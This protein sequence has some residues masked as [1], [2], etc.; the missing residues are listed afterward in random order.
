[1]FQKIFKSNFIRSSVIFSVASFIVSVIGYLINLIVARSFS[2]SDYGELM[3]AMSYVLFLSVPITT[4]GLIVIQRI[5]KEDTLG[6]K[7]IALDL[8]KW[9]FSELKTHMPLLTI[10][11][12]IFSTLVY[13]KGNLGLPAIIFVVVT[14][15]LM[16]FQIFYSSVLQSFKNF[17]WAGLFLITIILSKFSFAI[18]VI[19]ISPNLINL[20][21]AF[22]LSL[23]IGL[24]VGKKMIGNTKVISD[25]N[26]THKFLNIFSYLKRKGLLI[27][28]ITTLG[29]VG[30]ANVDIILV[31]KF[32]PADQAGLYSSISL[33]GKII[34]YVSMPLSQVAFS[35]FTGKDSKHNSLLILIL[36]SIVYLFIGSVSTFIYFF[37]P[38][39]VINVIF[40]SKFLNISSLIWM[41]AIFGT[42][43]SLVTLYAQFFIARNS[44]WGALAIIALF[45]QFFAIFFNH[46]SLEEVLTINIFTSFLL[47]TALVGKIA[48]SDV[49][50]I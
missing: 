34:L 39:L 19:V 10:L 21:L 6:R 27:T 38:D 15:F 40:G 37:F 42:L 25:K 18:G 13:F 23:I 44:W 26:I 46:G 11:V 41:V 2:L 32:F 30:L 29:L 45:I 4:F 8:E 50:K 22:T 33:L 43:Y 3:T 24:A 31:K 7:K 48:L 5:G 14:S 35:F 12:L 1:M 20:F 17:F 36:L 28:L 16:L 49:R 9:L 47:L